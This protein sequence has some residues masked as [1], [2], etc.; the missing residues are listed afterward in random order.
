MKELGLFGAIDQL[1]HF[2]VSKH[3]TGIYGC[4]GGG[5]PSDIL[6]VVGSLD[7]QMQNEK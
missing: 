6:F 2:P 3:V 7:K 5:N 1:R 4:F